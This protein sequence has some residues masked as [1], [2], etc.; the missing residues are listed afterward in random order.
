[1]VAMKR[2]SHAP[3]PLSPPSGGRSGRVI[4]LPLM[5]VHLSK[6]GAA[7]AL[8]GL[9]LLGGCNKVEAAPTTSEP[10][11]SKVAEA[12]SQPSTQASSTVENPNYTVR[13]TVESPCKHGET[14]TALVTVDAKGGFHINDKYPYRFKL[15]EPG[16]GLKYP[17]PQVGREDGTFSET[18]AVLRVPFVAASAGEVKVGGT[19]SFSV[20]SDEKCLID[21]QALE[22]AAKV[23]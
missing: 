4:V 8:V 19:L 22:T 2:N 12:P 10:S 17:K 15:D 20:C 3:H 16:P 21:K 5:R 9:S 1:M 13:F 7:A 18:K 6:L 14:C 23:E 11:G